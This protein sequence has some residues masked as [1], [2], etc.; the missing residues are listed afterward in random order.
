M[1]CEAQ[2][3]IRSTREDLVGVVPQEGQNKT[4]AVPAHCGSLV[5]THRATEV[6]LKRCSYAMPLPPR[7]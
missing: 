1:I 7:T 6:Q 5:Q 4:L 3:G 2:S